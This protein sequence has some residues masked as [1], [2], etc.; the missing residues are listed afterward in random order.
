MAKQD[1]AGNT[2]GRLGP[3]AARRTAL[4][5]VGGVAMATAPACRTDALLASVVAVPPVSP[6]S[7]APAVIAEPPR[8]PAPER[9]RHVY[10]PRPLGALIPAVTRAAFRR[11]SP[12]SVQLLQDWADIVGPAV[13]AMALPKRL[14]GT[15]LTLACSGAAALE[16]QHLSTA[17]I[18]RINTHFG[19]RCVEQLR[20]VQDG[21]PP[22][23]VAARNRPPPVKVDGLP[24]GE[25]RD[26]LARLGGAVAARRR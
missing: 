13:A 8:R 20:F 22:P 19:R 4:A 23:P 25:L 16:L 5:A 21:A 17:L 12:A 2:H 10:G 1:S 11:R 18:E 7:P 26:A 24:E 3:K 15:S 6:T 14:S 9:P